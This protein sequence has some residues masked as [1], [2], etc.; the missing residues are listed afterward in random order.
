M[1][2]AVLLED[3]PAPGVARLRL[4]RPQVRNA[5]NLVLRQALA[6]SFDRLDADADTH[7]ILLCGHER[8]FCAGADLNE[9]VDASPQEVQERRMDRL[10]GAVAACTKPVVA[11]VRGAAI[12]GGCELALHAD[13]IVAADNARFGQPEV[14]LGIMPGGG[15]TQRIA[16]AVGKA[17]AMRW[18]LVGEPFSAAEAHAAGLVSDLV[19]DDQVES[20][21]LTL[22][23]ILASLPPWAV[24]A[25]KQC[26]LDSQSL[27]LEAGLRAERSAFQV[28]FAGEAKQRLMRQALKR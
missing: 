1:S 10:W 15:A 2:D 16:R 13:I 25:T 6:E 20:H 4:N 9:Y 14:R 8:A 11:G 26:V 12:G 22:A 17:K 28:L 27:P 3:R 23:T 18:M 7:A 24:R 21:A 19:P 5:L